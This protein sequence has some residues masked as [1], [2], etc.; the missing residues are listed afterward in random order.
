MEEIF[1]G[2]V[3]IGDSPIGEKWK[4]YWD[5]FED[6][7]PSSVNFKL[8]VD[9]VGFEVNSIIIEKAD[10]N[11]RHEIFINNKHVGD[12]CTKLASCV[13]NL[14]KSLSKNFTI[15]IN[16]TPKSE[17]KTYDDYIIYSIKVS[18]KALT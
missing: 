14:D 10:V 2:P 16:N 6:P 13:V 15:K 18:D 1:R 12:L 7:D 11:R 4:D 8:E 9:E 5:E 17:S 3:H